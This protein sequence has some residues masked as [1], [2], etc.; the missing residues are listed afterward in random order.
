MAESD[1]SRDS[2]KGTTGAIQGSVSGVQSD[3]PVIGIF[4]SDIHFSHNPPIARSNEP[5]WYAA[6]ERPFKELI[7]LAYNH[8]CPVFIAGDIFDKWKSP[9][10]LISF[11]INLFRTFAYGIYT[12]PGQ[13]DLPDHSIEQIEKS[14]YWTLHSAIE[15]D[16]GGA[17]CL[18]DNVFHENIKW[19]NVY[20][21]PYGKEITPLDKK[22]MFLNVAVC[23]AYIWSELG[24]Y[25]PESNYI[26]KFAEKLDGYDFA[27]FGDN[28]LPFIGR[29]GNCTVVNC[30]GFYRRTSDQINHVPQAYLLHK[31]GQLI[32]HK[33]DVSQDIFTANIKNPI[34]N[35]ML[36]PDSFVS[37]LDSLG[38]VTIDYKQE[39]NQA[40]DT[41]QVTPEVR[42]IILGAIEKGE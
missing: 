21:F 15:C 17:Y 42:Q 34:F 37:S 35:S 40:M 41:I 13:H 25:N 22:N 1:T 10:E 12:I 32:T 16:M 31:N 6:M 14:A 26:S 3:N 8:Q 9:P 30:G 20:S 36:S 7:N 23:H 27:F 33:F 29:A 19:F 24:N 5:D 38:D 28:H 18:Y 39:I 2:E 11:V 4:C